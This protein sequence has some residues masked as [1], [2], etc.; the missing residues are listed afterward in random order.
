MGVGIRAYARSVFF[1]AML[2][3]LGWSRGEL[4]LAMS[5]GMVFCAL[6]NPFVGW[7]VDKHG[8]SRLMAAGAFFFG[9]TL[10]LSSLINTLWYAFFILSLFYLASATFTN[11]PVQATIATW[12]VNRRG[13]AMGVAMAGIGFGGFLL[14]PLSAFLIS[15]LGWRMAWVT[16]GIIVWVVVIPLVLLK[17]KRRPENLGFLPNGKP[18][19]RESQMAEVGKASESF[20]IGGTQEFIDIAKVPAFWVLVTVFTLVLFPEVGI[21][22]H[23]FAI[24]TDKGIS[25]TTAGTMVGFIGFASVIGKLVLCYLSDRLPLKFVLGGAILLEISAI[26]LLL[27]EMDWAMWPFV[28]LWGFS[29]GGIVGLRPLLVAAWFDLTEIGKAIGLVEMVSFLFAGATGA[30]VMGYIFDITASY[31]LSLFLCIGCLV[32]GLL[33]LMFLYPRK[34]N[35]TF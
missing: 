12:F 19:I 2:I 27:S 24:L 30:P 14:S 20:K 18:K 1:K 5:L 8:A 15:E 16:L 28:L 33:L 22:M 4:A 29:M 3:D 6:A 10:V 34:R 11:V 31:E 21:L 26:L 9:I 35:P 25:V 7:W 32:L 13:L 23:S 17:M